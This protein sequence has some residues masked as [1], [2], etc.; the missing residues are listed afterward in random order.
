[1]CYSAEASFGTWAFG[2]VAT[3]ILWSQKKP[4]LFP[5]VVSQ[6]Q[7]VEGLRW[8]RIVD[9]RV[10]ALL[11]KLALAAQ[12]VAGLYEAGVPQYILPYVIAQGILELLYGS[13]DLR[14]TVAPDGHFRWHWLEPSSRLVMLPYWIALTYAAVLLFPLWFVGVLGALYAYYTLRHGQYKTEGSLWCVS[15][16]VMW[17]YYLLR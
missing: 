5:L 2:L 9:E 6:M 16:N 17:I 1:M 7:L 12:P 15:V 8:I 14:F 4:F 10:L 11:G 3:A 13:T